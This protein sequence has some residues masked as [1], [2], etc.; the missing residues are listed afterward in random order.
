MIKKRMM[1]VGGGSSGK[2]TLA[3]VINRKNRRITKTQDTIYG[4]YTI[5]T[6]SVYLEIPYN[7]RFLVA[8]AQEAAILVCVVDPT[9]TRK[10]F[11]PRFV[12]SFNCLHIGVITKTDLATPKQMDY[13]RHQLYEIGV[14]D[15]H[16]VEIDL[17]KAM[18]NPEDNP[19]VQALDEYKK[20][21]RI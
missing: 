11:P 15:E 3:N 5:D 18:E 9:R 6:P 1:I 20:Y 8:T 12:D 13:A 2:S 19:A 7:Y 16:I 14:S 17:L 10:V 4:K 21:C